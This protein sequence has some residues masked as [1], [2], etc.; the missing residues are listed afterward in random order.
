[1]C[2]NTGTRYTGN[3]FNTFM[4]IPGEY[5]RGLA[6]PLR[7]DPLLGL[8]NGEQVEQLVSSIYTLLYI[9]M[10]HQQQV[11]CRPIVS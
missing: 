5:K 7:Y 9:H 11:R 8:R 1:M 3:K 2:P 6:F 4:F 10:A